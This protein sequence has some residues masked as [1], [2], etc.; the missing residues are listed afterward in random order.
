MNHQGDTNDLTATERAEVHE[1]MIRLGRTYGQ[2]AAIVRSRRPQPV[3]N[4]PETAIR[5]RIAGRMWHYPTGPTG[6]TYLF[7]SWN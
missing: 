7:E 1:I 2:A 5:R 3:A 6:E 4:L